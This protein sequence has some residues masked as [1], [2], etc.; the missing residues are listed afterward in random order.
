MEF[1][2]V[3]CAMPSFI[4]KMKVLPD[5]LLR[6]VFFFLS[7]FNSKV[8]R[9]H[10]PCPRK[11]IVEF[12]RISSRFGGDTLRQ[13]FGIGDLHLSK[14]TIYFILQ[15]NEDKSVYLDNEVKRTCCMCPCE[16]AMDPSSV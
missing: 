11:G 6:E 13:N 9:A 1:L 5:I 7:H 15:V 14:S 12:D 4:H 10:R 8:D 3:S 16:G 2:V